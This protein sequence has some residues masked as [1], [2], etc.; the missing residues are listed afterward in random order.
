MKICV[1][2][3]SRADYG[4]L[5]PVL[6]RLDLDPEIDLRIL[7]SGGH[8]MREQGN[9][10][11]VIEKDGFRVADRVE[12]VLAGD[13]P[14]SVAKSMGLAIL[15]YADALARMEPDVLCVLGD[16]YE[17][18]SAV[19]AALP[20]NT[21]V[22]HFGGGQ[23]TLGSADDRIRHAI[24]RIAHL[25]F[26]FAEEDRKQLIR[27]GVAEDCVHDAGRMNVEHGITENLIDRRDLE[28]RL[29]RKLR[30]PSF[31][32]TLHPVTGK[33]EETGEAL[34]AL[35]AVLAQYEHGTIVFT[36]PN[37]DHGS[38]D[39]SVAISQFVAEHPSFTTYVPSLGQRGYLGLVRHCDVVVGNSS[40]GL[41]EAPLLGTP[42]VNIG[43]RQD[44]RAK[45]DSVFD[46]AATPAGVQRAIDA[47]LSCDVD[48]GHHEN[49]VPTNENIDEAVVE[50]IKRRS[51]EN[52][53]D[54]R[55]SDSKWR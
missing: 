42:T 34:D 21:M 1:F 41:L 14:V 9:T 30:S 47:A 10:V 8:L 51:R 5:I 43:S 4:P 15:G 7:A 48:R 28:D 55:R 49:A 32:V 31:A 44:G 18:L 19:L 38:G 12:M 52:L 26:V 23:L 2:T 27:M 36:A 37:V 20:R 35:L 50:V 53:R 33:P 3:G 29:G 22:V 46:C 16:R 54:A 13:S 24:S 45:A 25:H 40:S 6:R 11:E 17:A 39:I